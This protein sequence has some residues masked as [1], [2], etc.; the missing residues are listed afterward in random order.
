MN[1]SPEDL[2]KIKEKARQ[3]AEQELENFKKFAF[4]GSMIQMAVAFILGAAFKN[5]VSAISDDIIMP[6]V[7]YIINWML[8]T[9]GTHWRNI[10]WTPVADMT[11]ELGKFLG[12]AVDFLIIAVILYII[13]KKIFRGKDEE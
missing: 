4:Q 8:H 13:W 11:F 9:T 1:L 3:E 12:A 6:I 2:E 5:V 7:N 10:S